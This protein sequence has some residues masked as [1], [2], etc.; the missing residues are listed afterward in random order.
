MQNEK[1][2]CPYA[3]AIPVAP[4]RVRVRRGDDGQFT[5]TWDGHTAVVYVC[6]SFPWTEPGRYISLRDD[7]DRE[8]AL[9][10]HLDE[11]VEDSRA[12]VELALAEAAFVL[13]ITRID[14]LQEEFEIR[15][16][17]VQTRQGPRTFQTRRDDWPRKVGRGGLLVRDV[18]GDLFHIADPSELDPASRK[19]LAVYVD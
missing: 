3:D 15:N 16:W 7:K 17:R 18:A 5:A 10:G 14:D 12:A 2:P 9:V 1:T 13:E 11:L 8:I 19:R 4:E 6:R